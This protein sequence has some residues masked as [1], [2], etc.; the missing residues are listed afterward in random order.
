MLT[1][2]ETGIFKEDADVLW[3]AEERLDFCTFI[4]ANPEAGDVIPGS[5]RCRSRVRAWVNAAACA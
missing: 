2:A 3:T 5:G 1:V 4:A